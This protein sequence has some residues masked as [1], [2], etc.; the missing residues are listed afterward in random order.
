MAQLT[1]SSTSVATTASLTTVGTTDW[2]KWEST[3][4]QIR[5][6]GGGS[7]IS[8][9]SLIAGTSGNNYGNDPRTLT[10]SD[11]TPTASGSSTAGV[12]QTPATTGLGFTCTAP[13]DTTLQTIVFYGGLYSGQ[14]TLTCALSDSSAGPLT[15]TSITTSSNTAGDFNATVQF[16]AASGGQTLTLSWA[17]S[18]SLA[19]VG[20][21]TMCGAA[22]ASVAASDLPWSM[23]QRAMRNTLLRM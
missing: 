17:L 3:A 9:Y 7:L 11:G 16:Q 10:W 21:V 5:K 22:L 19:G 4:S 8:N 13:A 2:I 6:S 1:G 12:Y 20:N 15:L 18:T 23:A 14:G